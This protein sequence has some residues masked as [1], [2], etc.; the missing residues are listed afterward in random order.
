MNRLPQHLLLGKRGED[1]AASELEKAGYVI[2]ER[3]WRHGHLELDMI[4]REGEEIVFVEV[5][6]RS[7]THNGGAPGAITA[8]KIMRMEKAARYWLSA[9]G[10]WSRPCRFDVLC[11]YVQS[12]TFRMEHYRNAFAATLGGSHAGWQPW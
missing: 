10:V 8:A 7:S 12:D 4:C 2:L 5:K 6:T 1:W 3:N 11:L 9:K